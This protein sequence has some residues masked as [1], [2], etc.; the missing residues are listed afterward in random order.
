MEIRECRSCGDEFNTDE[1]YQGKCDA[2]EDKQ[3]VQG[4]R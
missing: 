4:I 2:C 3:M 1:M